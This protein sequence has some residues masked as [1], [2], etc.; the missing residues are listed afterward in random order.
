M[1][2]RLALIVALV[3]LVAGH[4]T[5]ADAI[6]FFFS[7]TGGF[8]LGS[9]TIQPG[10]VFDQ[11]G[12][13][14]FGPVPPYNAPTIPPGSSPANTY[15][16]IGWGCGATADTC[17]ADDA[18]HNV[19]VAT[20]PFNDP[21]LGLD[22]T[23]PVTEPPPIGDPNRSALGIVTFNGTVS[24]NSVPVNITELFHQNNPINGNFLSSVD[25]VTTL[26][27]STTPTFEDPNSTVS[28]TFTETINKDPCAAPNPLGST[29]DDFWSFTVDTFAP[30]VI[31]DVT[32][33]YLL[34]F[35]LFT[36]DPGVAIIGNTVFTREGDTTHLFVQMSLQAIPEPASLVL[37]GSALIGFVGVHA[38]RRRQRKTS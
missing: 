19:V 27:I 9:A 2:K 18:D 33:D 22:N 29:C 31:H 21:T 30:V 8:E 7:H 24:D 26:R 34:S 35:N 23:F 28:I 25:I 4:A 10:T 36:D 32:G 16:Q 20:S 12:V 3:A 11:G 6:T 15:A 37:L 13:E 17:A 14:F 1:M 5:S 38:M